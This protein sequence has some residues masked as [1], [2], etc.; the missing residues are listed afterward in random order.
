MPSHT[1]YVKFRFLT[2]PL[3]LFI[4]YSFVA[5]LWYIVL[6]KQTVG[7][8]YAYYIIYH[9]VMFHIDRIHK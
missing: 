9:D 6:F 5:D 2:D 4:S 8:V 7:T 1:F 3:K